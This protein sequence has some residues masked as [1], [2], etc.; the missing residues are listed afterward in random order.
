MTAPD[1][2]IGIVL[3]SFAEPPD[4]FA[5]TY[6]HGGWTYR[7]LLK[8]IHRAARAPHGHGIGRGDALA[9]ATGA[10]PTTFAL[11]FAANVLGCATTVLYDDLASPVLADMLRYVEPAAVIVDPAH[12]PDR[13]FAAIEQAPA[14]AVWALGE[15]PSTVNVADAIDTEPA[16]PTDI[17]AQPEDLSSIRLTDGSTGIP[18]GIPQNSAPPAYFD[19]NYLK[20]WNHTQLICTAIGHLGD[21]LA[22]VVVTAGGR[23]VLQHEASNP[24]QVLDAIEPEQITFIWMQPAMLHQI[25]DDPA[26]ATTDTSSLRSMTITGGPSTPERIVQALDRFGPIITQGYGAYETGQITL[27]TP[28]EHQRRELLTSV[29]RPVPG[30]QVSIATGLMTGCYKQ[31]DHTVEAMHEGWYHTGDLGFLD[32]EGYL[33]VVGRSKDTI[34]DVHETVH[35]A[36]VEKVRHRH[37]RIQQAAVFGITN[38]HDRDEKIAAAIVPTPPHRLHV[39]EVADWVR[40]E[41]RSAYTPEVVLLLDHMPTTGSNKP[42]RIMLRQLATESTTNQSPAP[43]TSPSDSMSPTRNPNST[44][45]THHAR[46]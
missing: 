12:D 38:G 24:A 14:A 22:E 4:R 8:H 10:D 30:V 33:S 5:I 20:G 9:L 42:D 27:L 1:T 45:I 25:L 29:G 37:L 19:P 46:R 43:D 26:L 41:L 2:S 7:E 40:T 28:P 31:P 13:V 32:T 35:P 16:Q 3:A 21:Q 6:Q 39:D 34:V 23:V 11:R 36:H 17:Q 15:Y 18:K 44:K